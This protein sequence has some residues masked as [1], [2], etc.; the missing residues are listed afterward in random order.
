MGRHI[1][2]KVLETVPGGIKQISAVVKSE[3]HWLKKP[4]SKYTVLIPSCIPLVL[5][6]R[7]KRWHSHFRHGDDIQPETRTSFWSSFLESYCVCWHFL[8]IHY[9]EHYIDFVRTRHK[10]TI[11]VVSQRFIWVCLHQIKFLNYPVMKYLTSS[12]ARVKAWI[13][14]SGRQTGQHCFY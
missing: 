6:T 3:L 8:K 5:Q 13:F 14:R 9:V 11:C 7:M 10:E 12:Q 4:W 2:P 1:N